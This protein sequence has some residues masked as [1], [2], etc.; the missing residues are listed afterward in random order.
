MNQQLSDLLAGA[1]A[2]FA[3]LSDYEKYG[4]IAE[5]AGFLLFITGVVLF[6]L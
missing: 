6:F 5:V 1:N 4:W 3:Q 2:Y